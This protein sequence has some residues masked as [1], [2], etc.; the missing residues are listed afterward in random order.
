LRKGVENILNRLREIREDKGFSITDLANR[1]GITRQTIY[2]L[3]NEQD[4]TANSKTLRALA[5]ALGVKVS[6]FFIT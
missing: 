2:R 5:D 6:D 1:S 3:E 4:D